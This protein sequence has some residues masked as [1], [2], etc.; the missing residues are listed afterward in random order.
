[1]DIILVTKIVRI[2]E[3]LLKGTYLAHNRSFMDVG[4]YRRVQLKWKL[5]LTDCGGFD[6][7]AQTW[8]H[9]CVLLTS[10]FDLDFQV[11]QIGK[12]AE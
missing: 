6:C 11:F 4:Y 9:L 7:C 2:N 10:L 5:R 12:V 3:L 1:M 8:T